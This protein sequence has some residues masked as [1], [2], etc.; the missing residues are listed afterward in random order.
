MIFLQQFDFQVE[1]RHRKNH[2]N[3]DAVSRI[4]STVKVMA[5]VQELNTDVNALKE[6]Q[7]ADAQLRP[8]IKAL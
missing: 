1:Y 8:V 2:Q 4:P 7:L 5:V 6:S 3:A